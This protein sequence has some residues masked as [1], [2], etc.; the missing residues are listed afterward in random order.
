MPA[1]RAKKVTLIRREPE[2]DEANRNF[3]AGAA[4]ALPTYSQLYVA[5]GGQTCN[6][7]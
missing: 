1:H 6:T 5:R 7:Q 3:A 4:I 2:R